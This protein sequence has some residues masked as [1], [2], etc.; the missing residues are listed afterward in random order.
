LLRSPIGGSAH[1]G[2]QALA[3]APFCRHG[4]FHQFHRL[5]HLLQ[6]AGVQAQVLVQTVAQQAHRLTEFMGGTAQV[7]RFH[8][9]G[10]LGLLQQ[11]EQ[12]YRHQP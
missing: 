6:I 3:L 8:A 12:A 2:L 5:G 11:A 10:A 9:V 1:T 4:F 7:G